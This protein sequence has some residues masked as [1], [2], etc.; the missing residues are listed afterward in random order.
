MNEGRTVS[1]QV[2]DFHCSGLSVTLPFAYASRLCPCRKAKFASGSAE[3]LCELNLYIIRI[4]YFGQRY[5]EQ[6]RKTLDSNRITQVKLYALQFTERRVQYQFVAGWVAQLVEQRT[7]NPCVGG[8]IPPP[9]TS[10]R[11]KRSGECRL[12][13]RK[14]ANADLGN[15]CRLKRSE[16]RP[17]KSEET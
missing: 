5:F 9:A 8:S 17:G 4:N 16:V 14:A 7:E 15:T 12:P 13:H 2:P 3:D 6:I 11:S 10:L 1:A